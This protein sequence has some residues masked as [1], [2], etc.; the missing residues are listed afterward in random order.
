MSTTKIGINIAS[1]AKATERIKLIMET[2][3]KIIK[4]QNKMESNFEA[5]IICPELFKN[6]LIFTDT[7][8]A[9]EHLQLIEFLFSAGSIEFD[10]LSEALRLMNQLSQNERNNFV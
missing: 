2:I 10:S 7:E 5:A 8:R 3:E 9:K 6:A 1:A 4:K